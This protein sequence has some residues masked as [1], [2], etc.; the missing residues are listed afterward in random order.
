ME[1]LEP[2]LDQDYN[3]GGGGWLTFFLLAPFFQTK[4]TLEVISFMKATCDKGI[5]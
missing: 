1:L 2:S 4:F 5:P 3:G